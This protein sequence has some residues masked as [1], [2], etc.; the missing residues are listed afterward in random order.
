MNTM[1]R[2]ANSIA[3]FAL[4]L[5]VLAV[6]TPAQRAAAFDPLIDSPMYKLPDLP[7]APIES[8]LPDGAVELWLEFLK[9]PEADY[10]CKAAQTIAAAQRRGY[11]QVQE[12]IPDLSAA[13]DRAEETD[14][15]RL[16]IAECLIELDA[17]AAAAT[18][19]KRAQAG[20]SDLR[21][22]IEPALA[23]WDHDRARAV[24]LSRLSDATDQAALG[25]AATP[26]TE[27]VLA[28]RGLGAVREDK[29]AE[30]LQALA[31]SARTAPMV[32]L[33]AAAALGAVRAKGLEKDAARLADAS[34]DVVARLSAAALLARHDSPEAVAVLQRLADDPEPA[35]ARPAVGRLVAIN[36]DL[37]VKKAETLL[38]SPDAPL[39]SHAAMILFRLPGAR[40]VQ[41]LADMLDDPHPEVRVQARKHLLELG[42]SKAWRAEVIAQGTRKLA[43]A[44][45]RALE[46]A[47]ILLTQLHHKPAVQRLLELLEFERPEVN[48]AA[49]WGLRRLAVSE[50]VPEIET[51]VKRHY[52]R[53][54][55]AKFGIP[56]AVAVEH[57]L[58]QLIQLIGAQRYQ[59]ADKLLRLFIP[60]QQGLFEAR[61]AAVWSLGLLHEGK[62][63][64]ALATQLEERLNDGGSIPPEDPRVCLMSA[65][66]LGRLRAKQA[67]PSLQKHCPNGE[68]GRSATPNACCWALTQINGTPLPA[69]RTIRVTD[70]G[71]VLVPNN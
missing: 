39:R 69:P 58:S 4:V 43:G 3:L 10:R 40:H 13:L 35:V 63:D 46:Q 1:T 30:P 55:A 29:A 19:F 27:L 50:T 26:P 53:A 33:E 45:W 71:W 6:L 11:K 16:A 31:L 38:R 20:T 32:R 60:K 28:L 65:I 44:D 62:D 5:A 14:V 66:T 52:Q 49:G 67:L 37:I 51:H 23:R 59:P 56:D 8:R 22:L 7:L 34:G 18:L 42:L 47:A 70:L 61:A 25:K 15:V 41:L 48:V 17:R 24:W 21:C 2:S 64:P 36:P 54:A 68:L 9:R 12:A 57:R